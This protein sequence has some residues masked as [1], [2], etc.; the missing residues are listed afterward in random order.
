MVRSS[1]FSIPASSLRARAGLLAVVP[2]VLVASGFGSCY[3]PRIVE[4]GREPCASY[5]KLRQPLFGETHAHTTYSFDAVLV[6]TRTDPRDAY[7][8]A[9]GATIGLPPYD[10]QG[11]PMRTATLERPLDFAIVT[12]HA[13][14]FGESNVCLD[15][16]I[17]P[18]GYNSTQCVRF[19]E[20]IGVTPGG[21]IPLG[22]QIF[23]LPLTQSAPS[24]SPQVCGAGFTNC[25][26]QSA[27]V[28]QEIQAAAEEAYDRTSAC[29]FTSFVGYEWTANTSF[30]NL[31]RNVVFRNEIVPAQ[32][33]SYFE[34]SS[35]EDLWN[36]LYAAC[37]DGLPGCDVL[38]IPHGSNIGNGL[39]FDTTNATP[40][41]NDFRIFMEPLVEVSQ[42]KGESECRTGVGNTD[43]DCSF[44]KLDWINIF[45]APP[46]PDQVFPEQNFVRNALREGLLQESL[47][48]INPFRF[49][50]VGGTDTHNSLLGATEEY[51]YQ[52]HLGSVESTPE[53]RLLPPNLV[54][55]GFVANPGALTVLWS[56]ENS[57]ESL[58]HAMQRREA[59]ATSGTRPIVRFYGGYNLPADHCSAA[60]FARTGYERGVPMG[61]V[62]P[63]F[64]PGGHAPPKFSVLVQQDVG[65]PG[66]PGTPLQRV[67]IVKGWTDGQGGTQ[68]QVFEVAGDPQ[69]GASVDVATCTPQGT[70][71]STLCAVWEDPGFDPGQHAFYYAR[72]FENPTCRWSTH[73]CVNA[74]I[75][76][77]GTTP[78]QPGY[79]ACCDP[80]LPKTVQERA[81]TSPI[82]HTPSGL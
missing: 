63:P 8:F 4:A 74:G 13:E 7:G 39:M 78:S 26:A 56:E 29:E 14:Y 77:D 41:Y 60:N 81:W 51:S 3:A 71:F 72:V 34:A 25:L 24:R 62:L 76:C 18:S 79:E 27:S 23:G 15:P 12:D 28:W 55:Q 19:R 73:E 80:A 67:Q 57:R 30:S 69:N 5:Q 59:Y 2:L 54:P 66:H 53:F 70:G 22:F 31:H 40:E 46:D 17:Y 37:Q 11:Q 44:E 43:E 32:P 38:A 42:H 16:S 20:A 65:A 52:G 49:G 21:G 82:W 75:T 68:E 35:P 36:A 50:F 58:W 1:A 10:A 9:R 45:A 6:G 64:F 48:G 33:V 61:S 47:T